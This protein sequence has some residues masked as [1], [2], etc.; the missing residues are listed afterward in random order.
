[1]KKI[2][3]LILC[4][5][6]ILS[7]SACGTTNKG[8]EPSNSTSESG[9]QTSTQP[10]A[11]ATEDAGSS[12]AAY[13]VGIIQ[14]VQHEALDAATQ[15]FQ[16]ALK[17]LLGDKVSFD[18]Q[19]ASGDSATCATIA[20]QFVSNNYD[21]IMANATPALQAA[22]SATNSIPILG[23]SV[24]DYATALDIDNWTGV[25]GYNVSGTSDLAPLDKQ[26]EM[27]KE[28][29][30][31]VKN[32]GIL[33]CSAEPNSK[34]QSS[35]IQGYLKDMGYTCTEYTFADSNDVASVTQNAVSNSDILYIPTDNTAASCTEAI[36]NVAEPAGIPIVAGEEGICRGCGIATL[37]ISYYDLGYET[38]KMAYEV[39]ANGADVSKLE[40]QFAPNTTYKYM[41]DRA[42][43]LGVTVPDN[44]VAIEVQ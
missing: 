35:V 34:Y 12:D 2:F 36:N 3:A 26:A 27:I 4:L 1:M 15:G 16:D 11:P 31:D 5:S 30:P 32:I 28:L 40:V 41:A 29:F 37:S 13:T 33:Y 8:G 25:T 23:T 14:L 44:Y 24:T 17:E 43:K 22:F 9:D 10:T 42:A 38:G 39:L 21:L 6:M 20:N 19:N 7:L 18:L